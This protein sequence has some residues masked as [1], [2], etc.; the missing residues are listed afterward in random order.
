METV[1]TISREG[2]LR[3]LVGEPS[4]IV[5]AKIADR[6]NGL[7]RCFVERSPFV[8]VATVSMAWS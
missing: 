7:T 8:C 2:D 6:L 3:A 5:T 4:A 1:R